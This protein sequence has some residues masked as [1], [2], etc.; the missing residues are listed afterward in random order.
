MFVC[1]LVNNKIKTL[2]H[3]ILTKDKKFTVFLRCCRLISR[4]RSRLTASISITTKMGTLTETAVTEL[5]PV[6]FSWFCISDTGKRDYEI[7][8]RLFYNVMRY[9]CH[10]YLYTTTH[11]SLQSQFVIHKK[12]IKKKQTEFL[13]KSQ[14]LKP[15]LR[16]YIIIYT[17]TQRK[18]CFLFFSL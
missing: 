6:F 16:A 17:L 4:V 12:K 10:Q 1:H 18:Y 2:K 15:Q 13:A 5:P 9:Q 11:Y 7:C 14:H 3:I 8:Y